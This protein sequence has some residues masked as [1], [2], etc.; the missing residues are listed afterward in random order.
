MPASCRDRFTTSN[1]RGDGT[2]TSAGRYPP[3]YYAIVGIPSL[4]SDSTGGIYAMR[5]V[6]AAL[7]ALFVALA[8]T[9]ICV[10]SRRRFML[11]GVLLALTPMTL[12][13]GGVVNPNGPEI[14]AALC[15]WT[16]GL[17][18]VL[19]RADDPPAVS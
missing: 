7:S 2:N 3:L 6:D 5:L 19:E 9:S 12:F 13:L 11:V 4:V 16:A 18:L 14:C 17:I 8:L 1:T 15:M 10:W